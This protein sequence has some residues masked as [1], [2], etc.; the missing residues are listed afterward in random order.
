MG[1]NVMVLDNPAHKKI[2]CRG[3]NLHS[4][5]NKDEPQQTCSHTLIIGTGKFSAE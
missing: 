5:A 3:H 4:G 2:R 1:K